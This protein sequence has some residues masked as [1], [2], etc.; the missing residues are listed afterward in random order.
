[1][2]VQGLQA[3]SARMLQH[4]EAPLLRKHAR[5]EEHREMLGPGLLLMFGPGLL[6]SDSFG[7]V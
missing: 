6:L 4:V 1:M 5:V 7:R 2:L 3:E